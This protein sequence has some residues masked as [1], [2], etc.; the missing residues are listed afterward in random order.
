MAVHFPIALFITAFVFEAVGLVL[1]NDAVHKA[2]VCMY[3]A[4][5]LITPFV[6]QTGIWEAERIKLHHPILDQHRQYALWLMWISLAS[7]P[8]LWFTNRKAKKYFKALFVVFLI[9]TVTFVSLT[10]D[11]GGQMVFEYGVG[12]EQ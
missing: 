4:A 7:L 10:G 3:V 12:V 1:K 5:A 2:A 11:K 9:A 8:F 6:V